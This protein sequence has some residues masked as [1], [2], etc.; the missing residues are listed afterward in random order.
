M[1][2]HGAVQTLDLRWL[3]P[4]RVEVDGSPVRLETRKV[5]GLLAVLSLDGR[6][7]SREYLATLLWPEF[8]LHRAPA[9]LRRALASLQAS[10]GPGWLKAD[11][12]TIALCGP[13]KVSVDIAEVLG[14]VRAARSHHP[15]P[16]EPLCASCAGKLEEAAR[17]WCGDFLEGFNLKDCPGFDQWQMGRRDELSQEMGWTLERLAEAS[18]Q[19][20]RWE[21]AI[22]HARRWL[23]L[24]ELHEG[25]HRTLMFLYA[26]G[27]KRS[28]ALRQYDECARVLQQE[29]GQE[30]E[31]ATRTL[32]ERIRQRTLE[33]RR[34]AAPP[35]PSEPQQGS[36]GRAARCR[37]RRGA[38]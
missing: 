33:P 3:G 4:P 38:P 9:N 13:G 15:K 37:A 14:R 25:A 24:D 29:L 21:E 36:R 17:L 18:G 10:L 19:A 11:R 20:G 35:D 34:D 26:R 16:T 7:Q 8:D 22:G 32:R 5:T 2:Y 31:E 30:P 27:G 1:C 23:S 28:A 12:E 6:P